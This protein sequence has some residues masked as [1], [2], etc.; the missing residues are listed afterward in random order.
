MTATTLLSA[1]VL[2]AKGPIA[3]MPANEAR[4]TWNAFRC[5]HGRKAGG[6]ILTAPDG[7]WKLNKA[8]VPSY[9][10][11]LAPARSGGYGNV[12]PA[13]SYG[14]GGCAEAC[15]AS[16]GRSGLSTAVAGRQLRMDF[17]AAHPEAFVGVV[18][19]ELQAAVKRHGA[20]LFRPNTLSDI[21]WEKVAPAWFDVDGVTVYDY[22]KRVD[23]GTTAPYSVAVSANRN[24]TFEE[25][26]AL[27]ASGAKVAVVIDGKKGDAKPSTW[28][29][30]PAVDADKS[31]EWILTAPKGV[32]GLLTPKGDAKRSPVGWDAFVKP[33]EI[34]A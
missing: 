10:L 24:T 4:A 12:C 30:L 21:A 1:L 17:F 7:N 33:R 8:S 13:A 15:L 20:I 18:L 3:P 9:G 19:A 6:R 5:A 32:V 27:V 11:L 29:G 2:E 22:T 14:P 28:F 25:I 34:G 23:R 16:A 31:D 26:S